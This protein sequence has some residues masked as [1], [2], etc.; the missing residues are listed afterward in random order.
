VAVQCLADGGAYPAFRDAVFLDVGAFD[1]VE[2]DA[3]VPRQ[4]LLVVLSACGIDRQ[5]VR[6]R[7]G[8]GV[9]RRVGHWA[10]PEIGAIYSGA[11]PVQNPSSAR[12]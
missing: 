1:T 11:A 2:T 9:G 5:A 8:R 7:I 3:D 4:Q 10:S 6:Q 12:R